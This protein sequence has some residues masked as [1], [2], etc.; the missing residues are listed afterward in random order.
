MQQ[1]CAGVG[2]RLCIVAAFLYNQVL[3]LGRYHWDG[4]KWLSRTSLVHTS[5][6]KLR[7]NLVFPDFCGPQVLRDAVHIML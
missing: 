7:Y 5:G 4:S 1:D 2:I 6:R 3:V